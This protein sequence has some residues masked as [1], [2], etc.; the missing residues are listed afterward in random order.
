[1]SKKQTAVEWLVD[2]LSSKPIDDITDEYWWG[3]IG[4]AKE[5]ERRQIEDAYN[6]DNTS[7]FPKDVRAFN[8]KEYYTQTYV[9]GNSSDN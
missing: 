2:K 3:I 6:V 9:N 1:M 5:M 8:A 7:Y 4:E